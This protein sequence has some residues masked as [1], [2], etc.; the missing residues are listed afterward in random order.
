MNTRLTAF[1]VACLLIALLP[2]A[3]LF[4]DNPT[5]PVR[6]GTTPFQGE[7]AYVLDGDLWL[8]DLTGAQARQ[9]TT[10]GDTM[11]PNWSPDGRYLV[12]SRGADLESA[13]LY[14]LDVENGGEAELL[15]EQACCGAWSPDGERIAYVDLS[16]EE[17]ALRSVRP[18]GSGEE[19]LVDPLTYGRGAYPVG[20]LDWVSDQYLLAPLEII[21]E[22]SLDIHRDVIVINLWT[23]SGEEALGE[24]GCSALSADAVTVPES[25]GDDLLALAVAFEQTG[26]SCEGMQAAKGIDIDWFNDNDGRDFP[27]LAAPSFSADGTFLAAERYLESD[28]P[29]TAELWGVVVVNTLNGAE[30]AVAEGASQPAWRPAPPLD[31]SALRFMGPGERLVTLEP[32]LLYNGKRYRISYLTTGTLQRRDAEFFHLASPSFFADQEIRG[33]VVTSDG[34]AVTGDDLLRQIFQRYHAA[35]HLYVEP[36]PDLL[37]LLGEELETVLG[38]PLLMA[39][40]PARF[41]TSARNQNAAALRAMLS[42]WNGEDGTLRILDDALAD[43]NDAETALE[44]LAAIIEEQ[45]GTNQA[46]IALHAD[47]KLAYESSQETVA[48]GGAGLTLLRLVGE[49]LLLS[50]HQQARAG[51][52]QTYVDSFPSGVGGLNRDQLRA[53]ATVL[54]EAE[55]EYQQRL[56]LVVD[57]ARL[58]GT[59]ALVQGGSRLTQQAAADL[60]AGL[61][62]KYG[63]SLSAQ[64]VASLLS[65]VSVGLTVNSLLYGTDDLVANFQ[66]ARRSEDLRATFGAAAADVQRQASQRADVYD[67]DLAER[68]RIALLLD[69]LAAVSAYH[70]YADGVAASGRI[71]NLLTLINTLRGEDWQAATE[72]LHR[73]A[74]NAERTLLTDLDNPAMLDAAVTLAL[75]RT[76]PQSA[77]DG[78]L[79]VEPTTGMA[80]VFVPAGEFVMGSEDGP[81]DEQPQRLVYLDD[82]WIGQTEVTNAQFQYFVDAGGYTTERYWSDEGWQRR[83]AEDWTGPRCLDDDDFNAPDQ[84]VVCVSWYEADAYMRW[85]SETTGESYRLP[86]EAEWEKA[87]RGTDGRTFPWGDDFDGALLNFCDVNC[88]H[89][90]KD[91]DYDDGYAYTAPVGSYPDGASPY[92]ALDMAGNVWEWVND[93]YNSDYYSG[94]PDANPQG[95]ATGDYRVLRGGSW[96]YSGNGVRSAY[97]GDLHPDYW[98]GYDGFRSVRSP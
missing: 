45:Y 23:E 80:F 67:G 42:V 73:V 1:L 7:I 18:D 5:V 81:S 19:T 51:W 82:Y 72:G 15:M 71:P 40:S 41:L 52:L 28:D 97:R 20:K 10:D 63:T 86:T 9:L 76:R 55:E 68:Y 22:T 30:V 75:A 35:Y 69:A 33:L 58:E 36:P 31:P 13:D 46:L 6:Q 74:D 96:G 91:S 50:Q 4:A 26:G 11:E 79:L 83:R 27:W 25:N 90:W 57:F 17:P 98:N 34:R 94:A 93:W 77:T 65:A 70:A 24:E 61:A 66:L 78:D 16:G 44:V 12:Y 95:P 29:A 3:A 53:T 62:A 32:P 64:A 21:A 89:D 88:P 56:N 47:L 59:K 84:P 38:N 2:P 60:I 8:Y 54:A 37:P 92:G 49:L 85:L 87:A 48:W 14:L 39:M 43:A